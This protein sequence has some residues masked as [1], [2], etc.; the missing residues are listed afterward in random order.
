[1][2]TSQVV[3]V[4]LPLKSVG[5]AVCDRA[6]LLGKKRVALRFEFAAG[7]SVVQLDSRVLHRALSHLL[8]N[9]VEATPAGGTVTLRV[10]HTTGDAPTEDAEGEEG[11]ARAAGAPR[12][13]FEVRGS[14]TALARL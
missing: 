9:A 6:A 5:R 10:T 7:P 3:A 2:Y 11:T 12:V 8:V 4:A 1:M 14:R 13:R